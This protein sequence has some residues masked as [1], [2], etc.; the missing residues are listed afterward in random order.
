MRCSSS[1]LLLRAILAVHEPQCHHVFRERG[2]DAAWALIREG[3]PIIGDSRGR[4]NAA[5]ATLL[6]FGRRETAEYNVRRSEWTS[7]MEAEQVNQIA[8]SLSGLRQRA[9]DLRRYL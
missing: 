4:A 1:L 3:P 9:A 8:N 5:A 6:P 2:G 7:D